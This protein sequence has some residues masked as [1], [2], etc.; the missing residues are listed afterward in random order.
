MGSAY[1]IVLEKKIAGLDTSMDGKSLSQNVEALDRA[2]LESGV[3][4][5][6]A[7]FSMATEDAADF[8]AGEGM[9]LTDIELPSLQQFSAQEGLSTITAL[10]AHP[11]GQRA[12]VIDDLRACEL[13]LNQAAK[14]GVGWH[15]EIDI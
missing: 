9:D 7:F 3:Q 4:P 13:I 8:M 12:G 6:S 15:F 14:H 10:A 11:V 2:A 1:Y 5:L